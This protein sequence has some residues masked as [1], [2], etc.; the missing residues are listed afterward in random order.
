MKIINKN[1]VK[2]F[3]ERVNFKDT[4]FVLDFDGTITTS[5]DAGSFSPIAKTDSSAREYMDTISSYYYP[6]EKASSLDEIID[7]LKEH[8]KI[9]AESGISFYDFRD[10]L[11]Q[12]RWDLTMLVWVKFNLNIDNYSVKEWEFRK[13]MKDLLNYLYDNNLDYLVISAGVKNYIKNFFI[14][15]WFKIDR[16]H[17]VGNEFIT[18]DGWKAIW[19]DKELITPFTK[20]HLDYREYSIWTKEFAIQFWDSLWDAH[21]VNDSFDEKNILTIWITSGDDSRLKGFCDTFDIV[22]DEADWWVKAIL[23]LLEIKL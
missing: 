19:Y 11:M 22:L 16:M 7:T 1:K 17:I 20:Q 12:Q 8:D 2:S 3:L 18:D 10:I 23:E 6:V 14:H 4:V 13:W 15:H 21:I 5:W 9:L